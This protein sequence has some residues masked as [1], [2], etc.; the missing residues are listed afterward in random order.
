MLLLQGRVLHA[1]IFG[2]KSKVKSKK[3][4]ERKKIQRFG[5]W[6]SSKFAPFM[7]QEKQRKDACTF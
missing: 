7:F 3:R 6:S 5:L 4:K 2:Q 1:L